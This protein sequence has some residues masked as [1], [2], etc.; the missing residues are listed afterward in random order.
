MKKIDVAELKHLVN[1]TNRASVCEPGI[2]QGMNSLLESA[3]HLAKAYKGYGF[4]TS[5]Q[6]PENQNPGIE[7]NGMEPEFPDET[8]RVYY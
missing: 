5:D 6:V 3:L 2:R 4:L 8:R 7:W 1:E